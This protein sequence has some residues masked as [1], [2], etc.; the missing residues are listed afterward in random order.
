[1]DKELAIPLAKLLNRLHEE[2][3]K[4]ITSI[5]DLKIYRA[6]SESEAEKYR[7]EVF[8]REAS[9]QPLIH[10]LVQYLMYPREDF[11]GCLLI[12]ADVRT[13]WLKFLNLVSIGEN[14][15]NAEIIFLKGLDENTQSFGYRYEHPEVFGGD[16]QG[17]DK[18]AFFHVQQII[19]T[20]RGV[21]LPGA[22]NWMPT[23]CP[24]FFMFASCTY[25]LILYAVHSVCGWGCLVEHKTIGAIEN[26]VLNRLLTTGGEA[27]SAF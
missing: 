3:L 4:S 23:S 26:A 6:L 10:S 16:Q 25:E 21:P 15:I 13:G 20:S 17:A 9:G 1:M 2:S 22:I 5:R 14:K 7:R 18:H 24:A 19:Q 11:G 12:D 8:Y 27:Y